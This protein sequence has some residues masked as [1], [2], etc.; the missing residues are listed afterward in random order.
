MNALSFIV[1][2]NPVDATKEEPQTLLGWSSHG[3]RVRLVR[4]RDLEPEPEGIS[5]AE[6]SRRRRAA[7]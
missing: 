4:I 2:D 1:A 7:D 6:R 5:Q 3:G